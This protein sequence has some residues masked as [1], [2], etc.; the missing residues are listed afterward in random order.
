MSKINFKLIILT[1]ILL[2]S[3]IFTREFVNNYTPQGWV[4]DFAGI[5]DETTKFRIESIIIELEQKTSAEIAVVTIKSLEG[6]T[7]EDLATRLFEKWGV[8]KKG[9]DNGVMLI[10]A[11]EDKK[12]RIEVGYGLEAILTDGLCGEILD[13]YVVPYF[14]QGNFSDGILYGT[15]AIAKVIANDAGVE[16]TGEIY[17]NIKLREQNPLEIFVQILFFLIVLSIILRRPFLGFWITTSTGG[18]HIG[19]FR[20]GFGGGFGGFG[21][22]LSGGGG[23]TRG[24]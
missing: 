16:L 24:W 11:S 17:Q 6:Y 3:F 5:I 7:I 2:T 14:K 20:G 19:G 8:G 23:A 4:S 22:G 1:T 12:V 9:K 10:V 15:A 13:K 18:F 21:G